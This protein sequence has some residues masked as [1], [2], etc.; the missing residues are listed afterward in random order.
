MA[1]SRHFPPCIDSCVMLPPWSLS[2][3]QRHHSRY[4]AAPRI[5]LRTH[6]SPAYYSSK[7]AL[8]AGSKEHSVPHRQ[9]TRVGLD[10]RSHDDTHFLSKTLPASSVIRTWPART[11]RPWL[12]TPIIILKPLPLQ[13]LR[14]WRGRGIPYTL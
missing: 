12:G 10:R 13:S 1:Q 4:T 3:N 2:A 9:S 5:I 7:V 11:H 6:S 8:S 14:G